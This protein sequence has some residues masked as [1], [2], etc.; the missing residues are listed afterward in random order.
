[1]QYKCSPGGWPL[2]VKRK[3]EVL[4]PKRSM[5][6]A[7]IRNQLATAVKFGGEPDPAL[8]SSFAKIL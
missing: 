2:Q 1:M 8:N 7:K 3:E 5:M 4:D 6:L